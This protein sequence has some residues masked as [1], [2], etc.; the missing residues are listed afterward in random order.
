SF[1]RQ[2]AAVLPVVA[3]LALPAGSAAAQDPAAALQ[4][5]SAPQPQP[6]ALQ[7]SAPQPQSSARLMP[8]P[9][10]DRQQGGLTV[11]T[12]AVPAGWRVD[13]TVEWRYG[14]V[15][16]PVRVALRAEAPDGSAWVEFFARE[17]FYWL[18]PVRSPVNV[19]GR[20]LGMV[21]LPGVTVEQA[22]QRFIVGAYRGKAPGLRVVSA[23]SIDPAG[24][25]AAF[26]AS[27]PAG[28]D[29]Q[30]W[31][32]QY[33]AGGRTVDEDVF[34]LLTARNR[35]P[36][37]GPQ[38]TWHESHRLL[39]LPHAI[40][41]TDGRL[42]ALY[43]LLVAIATSVQLDPTW[44]AHRAELERR[45]SA[46]F[47]HQIAAGYS[48]IQA[49]AALSRSISANNDAMLASMQAQRAAQAQRDAARRAADQRAA[50]S[51]PNDG[52]SGYLR[53][54]ERMKDPYWGESERSYNQ[55]YHWTDG[56]G[57][58]RSSNDS[59]FNP[60]VGAGGGAT[61]QRMEPVR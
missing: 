8:Q 50:A 27:A 51:S 3:M 49:A 13:S 54:T 57:N 52:F 10:I 16:M 47:N 23:Q 9:I 61:W 1:A 34:G 32:L 38:G 19:G 11:G 35:I 56:Q 6:S 53:G 17:L 44:D 31:R 12:I 39:I 55:R 2:I 41:A 18:E 37:T 7:P 46:E 26:Q 30:M 21:H 14:D 60:N 28:S 25:A 58:Y 43:P 42:G 20:S 36:Y 33:Q 40:G 59:T 5:S 15:S 45:I 24:L 29:A 48:Q 22:M 4:R